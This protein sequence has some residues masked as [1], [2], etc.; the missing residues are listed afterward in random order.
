MAYAW[1]IGET[2]NEGVFAYIHIIWCKTQKQTIML[3]KMFLKE[4]YHEY[5]TC[6]KFWHLFH[7]CETCYQTSL[8]K[9][10]NLT[11]KNW[12]CEAWGCTK[13]ARSVLP[14]LSL[15]FACIQA[16]IDPYNIPSK[17]KVLG[18]STLDHLTC[19]FAILILML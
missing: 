1:V 16:P 8:I 5:D 18:L 19:C 7:G 9:A 10:A 12:K 15:C 6:K 2:Y 14:S 11:C 13:I 3:E 17:C 4:T